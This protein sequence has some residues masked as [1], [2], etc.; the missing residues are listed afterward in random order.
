MLLVSF[1]EQAPCLT[2]FALICLVTWKDPL[3][4]NYNASQQC[5]LKA[6]QMY[7]IPSGPL[8][9]LPRSPETSIPSP[10]NQQT[11]L[12]RVECCRGLPSDAPSIFC[13]AGPM[14]H[15][16]STELL[17]ARAGTGGEP[18][19]MPRSVCCWDFLGDAHSVFC[20]ERT[21]P[22]SVSLLWLYLLVTSTTYNTHV[23][24]LVSMDQAMTANTEQP[25]IP[26]SISLVYLNDIH[27]HLFFFHPLWRMHLLITP[28]PSQ[29]PG[30][31]QIPLGTEPPKH[32][33]PGP[34]SSNPP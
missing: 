2:R 6:H 15:S 34:L 21:Q 7:S 20:T 10:I 9:R 24:R 16:V 17:E 19:L 8:I 32:V 29:D 30:S 1:A 14:S 28:T 26:G 18:K 33:S 12:P 13:R 27:S 5:P 25:N 22:L 4:V 3:V 11:M 23:S 31:H